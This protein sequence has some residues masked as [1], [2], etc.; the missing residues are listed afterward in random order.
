MDGS[1]FARVVQQALALVALIFGVATLFAGT[2]VLLGADPGYA[3]Y[4]PLLVYNTAM[5]VA[6]LAA[7]FIGWGDA[8][9]GK[10]AAASIFLLNLLVLGALGYLRATGSA[11]AIESVGAMILRT[12][13]WLALFLG[14]YGVGRTARRRSAK[15][16]P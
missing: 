12:S 5:G 16:A 13:V 8:G 6:Y 15:V 4:R 2:R 11:I 9:R 7:G 1:R 14:W 3:V 10:N